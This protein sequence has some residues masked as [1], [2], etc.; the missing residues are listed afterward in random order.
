ML[1]AS[2]CAKVAPPSV[3]SVILTLA[4]S[5]LVPVVHVTVCVLP[6][7]Y[8]VPGVVAWLST[9]NGPLVLSRVSTTSSEATPPP[10]AEESRAVSRKCRALPV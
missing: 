4:A 2:T 7:A 9:R 1:A 5:V 6:P 8:G 10:W 3:E